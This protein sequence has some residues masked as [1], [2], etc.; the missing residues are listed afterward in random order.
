MTSV[1]TPHNHMQTTALLTMLSGAACSFGLR[2]T[3]G[4][5]T[6][7]IQL[8]LARW[9]GSGAFG[10]VALILTWLNIATLV[11]R[12]GFD[13]STLRFVAIFEQTQDWG[14]LE[15]FRRVR[16]RNT[17][18]MSLLVCIAGAAILAIVAQTWTTAFWYASIFMLVSAPLIACLEH[19]AAELRARQQIVGTEFVLWVARPAIWLA[20]CVL[21]QLV[22]KV[23]L[24][25]ASAIAAQACAALLTLILAA[26][27]LSRPRPLRSARQSESIDPEW[28]RSSWGSAVSG[29]S[30]LALTQ[31]DIVLVGLLIGA[32]ATGVYALASR[33]MSVVAL[34]LIAIRAAGA[35]Y[36]TRAVA[37]REQAE[38]KL[39]VWRM[40]L[41]CAI[42][43]IPAALVCWLL[44]WQ[45]LSWF[46]SD[47]VAA[48]SALGF[49]LVGQTLSS[50]CGPVGYL[51]SIT[52]HERIQARVLATFA[53]LNMACQW[54]CI[55]LWGITGAGLATCAM[56]IAW[57][58]T[59]AILLRKRLGFDTTALGLFMGL[60][61]PRYSPESTL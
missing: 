56:V 48:Q 43:T 4:V 27:L 61:K 59:M 19:W 25:A 37:R 42:Y 10:E 6:L 8:L 26:L 24:N 45:L 52:G 33:L 60:S 16:T 7:A 28:L 55:S 46:G 47:F 14:A 31:S 32:Q 41:L 11:I 23:P 34:G 39:T 58:T 3:G 15:Q 1:S 53:V 54:Y 50:L 30:S 12:C 40:N 51:A 9:L 35:S 20:L 13:M 36:L 2:L 57:N 5:I 49:L 22:F 21:A 18:A 38:L 44:S 29:I 17:L